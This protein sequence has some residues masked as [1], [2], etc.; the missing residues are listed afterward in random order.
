VDFTSF[1][2]IEVKP[3]LHHLKRWHGEVSRRSSAKA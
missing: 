2:A 3:D 1:P